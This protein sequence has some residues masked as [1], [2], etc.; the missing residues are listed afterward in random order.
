MKKL[1]IIGASVLTLALLA[2]CTDSSTTNKESTN[3]PNQ[4]TEE[5][6]KVEDQNATP[7]I[8]LDSAKLVG[9]NA[10]N[11]NQQQAV[12]KAFEVLKRN[13]IASNNEDIEG[14]LATMETQ[15]EALTRITQEQMFKDFNIFNN[16]SSDVEVL[17]VLDD[18]SE[19]K[20]RVTYD[21]ISTE[22]VDS[23]QNQRLTA[24]HI[25]ELV[26]GRYKITATKVEPSSIFLIDDK[27]EPI[28][29]LT[30]EDSLTEP[31]EVITGEDTLTDGSEVTPI[32][33][34]PTPPLTT[35]DSATD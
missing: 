11:I 33:T 16:F 19:I 25:L 35:E 34:E 17:S 18:L 8:S 30:T 1:S 21:I 12:E 5:S 2:A 26:E 13:I 32:K 4:P 23:F 7:E 24:V 10:F 15:D 14:Y 28:K 27:G 31:A 22:P 6:S 20:L 9:M 3:S 29:R